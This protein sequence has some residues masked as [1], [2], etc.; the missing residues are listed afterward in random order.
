MLHRESVSR[1]AD[2]TPQKLQRFAEEERAMYERWSDMLKADPYYNP[3]LSLIAEEFVLEAH[4]RT[5][6]ARSSA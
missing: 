6:A 4:P 5:L 3:N 1:G 2:D